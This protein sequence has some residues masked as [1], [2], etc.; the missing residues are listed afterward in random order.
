MSTDG[1]INVCLNE[2]LKDF[3]TYGHGDFK[4]KSFRTNVG[5]FGLKHSEGSTRATSVNNLY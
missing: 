4:S 2:T 5:F 3:S 1:W